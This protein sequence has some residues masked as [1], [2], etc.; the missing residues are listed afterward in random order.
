M[1]RRVAITATL[2]GALAIAGALW[3]RHE[4]ASELTKEMQAYETVSRYLSMG[5]SSHALELIRTYQNI[6][7]QNSD[8]P[9]DW[10]IPTIQGFAQLHDG[11]AL[12]TIYLQT[13]KKFDNN[14][15]AALLVA[16][17]FIA[18]GQLEPYKQLQQQW[19]S[20]RNKPVSWFDLSVDALLAEGKQKEAIAILSSNTFEGSSDVG[21]LQRL[22][23]LQAPTD[24]KRAWNSLTE[25]RAK[26]PNNGSLLS[27]R[28]Q[29]FELTN[30][31]ELARQEYLKAV[32]KDPSNVALID[33]LG[34]FYRRHGHYVLAMETWCC[35]LGLPL[36]DSLWIKSLFWSRV[37]YP[38]P[39]E[40]NQ[41]SIPIGHLKPFIAYLVAIRGQPQFWD[42]VA[43]KQIPNHSQFSKTQQAAYWLKLA[44]ALK[45]GKEKQASQLLLNNPFRHVLWDADL[46]NALQQ[47]LAYR[48][49]RT[50]PPHFHKDLT[51][52]NA[53]RHLFFREL[54]Q[55]SSS[56][57]KNL[58]IETKNLLLSPYAIPSTF[59]AAG[60]LE[61]ALSFPLPEVLPSDLPE[62][63][64]F[65]Y[66]QALRFN[67]SPE[68]ALEFASKQKNSPPLQLLIGELKIATG[69]F[70]GGIHQL[71]SLLQN[72]SDIGL[73]A[74]W[75][76]SLVQL[77]RRQ[78]DV[79]KKTIMTY[80]RL[81]NHLLG[82]ETL[83]RIAME[84]GD[85]TTAD[86]LY[87]EIEE[88]STEAKFYLARRA[89][90]QQ[91][92][93]RAAVLTHQL[94][95][96]FPDNAQL[97]SELKKIKNFDQKL[98]QKIDRGERHEKT[99]PFPMHTPID[100]S[101]AAVDAAGTKW[102]SEPL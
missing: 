59:L 38:S 9:V 20:R 85:V 56:S 34:E 98:N 54:E 49:V 65:A 19:L 83:A 55:L 100:R 39:I 25:A 73:R 74:A 79:A 78:F 32:H 63:V 51:A 68:K 33:Q 15:E 45:E 71:A 90:E 99:I 101:V 86:N 92:W 69:D 17:E 87:Q 58:S 62:W 16:S 29:I 48:S 27:A 18:R 12:L 80:P 23:V 57:S 46:H 67:R 41:H 81:A 88:E 89:Y 21:R 70:D 30:K 37:V 102:V 50:L 95:E 14:E 53:D 75:V 8:R 61:S 60:W 2:I 84:A 44:Q 72:D 3:H 82:R 36:S 24:L 7:E 97:R 26:D 94:L 40:W 4:D 35:G 1:S 28:A 13:P 66:T 11:P 31:P 96:E 76:T 64:A 5:E 91:E 93:N 43:F 47:V 77:Q 6:D 42:K 22:A 10:L 52:K